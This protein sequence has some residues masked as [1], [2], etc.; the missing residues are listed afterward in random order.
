MDQYEEYRL[1]LIATGYSPE[2]A[3]RIAD[4]MKSFIANITS[5]IPTEEGK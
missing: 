3:Q 5:N 1:S 2:M 4:G